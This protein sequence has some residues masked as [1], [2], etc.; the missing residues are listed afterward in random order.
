MTCAPRSPFAFARVGAETA[1]HSAVSCIMRRVRAV[2]RSSAPAASSASLPP[3]PPVAPIST[4]SSL[5][6]SPLPSLR[7]ETS[8]SEEEEQPHI[9]LEVDRVLVGPSPVQCPA[10]DECTSPPECLPSPTAAATACNPRGLNARANAFLFFLEDVE[11]VVLC[12]RCSPT[13]S[14]ATTIPLLTEP[15][16][17]AIEPPPS[18]PPTVDVVVTLDCRPLCQ[19]ACCC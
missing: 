15:A 2:R 14:V 4:P 6:P 3:L 18:P 19:P 11:A 13:P 10:R 9:S 1:S 8:S 12:L 5:L 7:M 17:A 16:L